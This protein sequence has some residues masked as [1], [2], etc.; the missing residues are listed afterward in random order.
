MKSS[1]SIYLR[2]ENNA[3]LYG[4]KSANLLELNEI[5]KD[6]KENNIQ[7]T[8][9]LFLPIH[10]DIIKNHLDKYANEWRSVWKIVV[11]KQNNENHTLDTD[12]KN[13]LKNLRN[14]IK[15]CFNKYPIQIDTLKFS[16]DD[17]LMVRSTGFED[18]VD[19]ANP[20][21]NKS[22]AAIKNTEKD[23]STAIG[24][25]IA[26]YF[27]E[28]SLMQRLLSGDSIQ[29]DP[30]MPVL[31]QKMIGEKLEGEEKLENIVASGVMYAKEEGMTRIDVAPGHGELIVNSKAPFDTFEVSEY[32]IVH[33]E[34]HKKPYRVIPT[35]II[36]EKDHPKRKLI[37]KNNPENL[38]KKPALPSN[39]AICISHIG[40]EIAKHYGMP[41]DIEFIYEANKNVLNIVQARPIPAKKEKIT[42]STIDPDIWRTIKKDPEVKIIKLEVIASAGNAVKW[43]S[44]FKQVLFTDTIS[45]ALRNYLDNEESKK[46]LGVIVNESAPST[47]HEAAQFNAMGI[48]VF[49]SEIFKIKNFLN[50]KNVRCILDVQHQ[51]MVI[52]KSQLNEQ[53]IVPGLYVSSKI[54]KKNIIKNRA[55]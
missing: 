42:A 19:V 46:I 55:S 32:D 50:E 25:V 11:E 23:I 20:G 3:K 26:S 36:D 24:K 1:D 14:L 40:R 8:V 41:M 30:F 33:A 27:S 6:T 45:I 35:E 4:N 53:S 31:I 48:P 10:D 12:S 54:P 47:S 51:S 28:K 37:L 5:C 18:T 16:N 39:I 13:H 7:V 17:L 15:D 2:I 9:P 38:Q 29:K 49:K 44:E 52:Y 43:I 34:I 21:G 22:L